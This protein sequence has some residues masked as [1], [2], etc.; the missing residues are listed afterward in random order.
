MHHIY[1]FQNILMLAVLAVYLAG[2]FRLKKYLKALAA[3]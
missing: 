2:S 1:I 3:R